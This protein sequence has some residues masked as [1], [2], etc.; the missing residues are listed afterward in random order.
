MDGLVSFSELLKSTSSPKYLAE[1]GRID[2]F[3][4][5]TFPQKVK[6]NYLPKAEPGDVS[7]SNM[8]EA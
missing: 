7:F 6:E 1:P 4:K 8:L 5:E 3:K 2:F